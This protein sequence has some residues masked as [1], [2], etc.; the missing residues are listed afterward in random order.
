[1]PIVTLAQ[2][3]TPLVLT[4]DVGSSSL[5]AG[6]FDRYARPVEDCQIRIKYQFDTT[7]DGGVEKDP[8]ELL[9]VVFTALDQALQLIGEKGRDIKAVAL[10]TFW[11]TVMGVDKQFQPLTPLFSWADTR[12][13]AHAA[14][15]RREL[16][17]RE[18]H[19]RT[20]CILHPSYYPAKLRW[21]AD[22][23]PTIYRRVAY[24]LS[25]GEY[26]YHKIFGT[27]RASISIASGTGLFNQFDCKWDTVTLAALSITEDK[28]SPLT[29]LDNPHYGLL[30]E[31]AQRWQTLK[32]IPWFP[33]I[34]DGAAGNIGSGCYTPNNIALMIGTSGA[35]R[36]VWSEKEIKRNIE[37]PWGLWRYRVDKQRP[38][39]GGALSEGGNLFAWMNS[40]LALPNPS[41][42][43]DE[44]SKQPPD[45]HG[46]TVLPFLAGERSPGWAGHARAVVT[47]L[48]LDTNAIE[49]L[50]AGLESIAFRFGLLFSLLEPALLSAISNKY[51][52][53]VASGG[54]LV[55][56][57]T[58]AQIIAD[59]LDR[60]VALSIEAESSSRGTALLALEQLEGGK[61]IFEM[62]DFECAVTYE[63]NSNR[64]R[65]YLESMKRQQELYQA[66]IHLQD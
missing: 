66:L 16:T 45:G 9:Q 26:F 47:G 2:A 64:H 60:P 10:D 30:P 40:T 41:D 22:T 31:Y 20:G 11:H 39:L 25:F 58:W 17:E 54:A 37:V 57:P 42:V 50:R 59:V 3:E 56:S 63:P 23:Q 38:V 48:S 28:L 14:Q 13:S 15:L 43:E 33:A 21:L 18:V 19:A 52:Q 1:M 53:V 55:K 27:N 44:L 7:P 35:M 46:L 36:V 6:F 12:S 24:W 8:D 51:I 5:R 32:D 34:G 49:I 29:D 65:I 62:V 61:R 4:L